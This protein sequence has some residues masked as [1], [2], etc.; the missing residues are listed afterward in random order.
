MMTFKRLALRGIALS[1]LLGFSMSLQGCGTVGPDSYPVVKSPS[2]CP[3]IGALNSVDPLYH[4]GPND[5]LHVLVYN[6]PQLSLD[7]PVRP[8]GR[9]SIPLVPD[10]Q[11]AGLTPT[12]LASNLATKLK[13]FVVDPNVSI[14]VLGA[15]GPFDQQIKIIGAATTQ[16]TALPFQNRMKVSDVLIQMHGLSRFAAGNSVIIVRKTG[17]SIGYE[18]IPVYLS[19]LN[20]GDI[21]QDIS[22]CPGDTLIIPQTSF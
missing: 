8:D 18:R 2:G 22:M 4:I 19:D 3:M 7:A 11:A 15:S 9:I 16:P 13:E 14:I 12:E 1:A 20:E 21:R 10:V 17:T 5:R 6:V